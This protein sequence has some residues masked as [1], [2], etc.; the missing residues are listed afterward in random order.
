MFHGVQG[1]YRWLETAAHEIYDVLQVC[2]AVAANKN[3]VI[4]SFDSDSLQPI[5]E[6]M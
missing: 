3:I 2:P 1:E 6:E 5:L 4:S